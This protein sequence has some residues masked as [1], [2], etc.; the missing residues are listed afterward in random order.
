MGGAGV[1]EGVDVIFGNVGEGG[2]ED[3]MGGGV[4]GGEVAVEEDGVE[5]AYGS[6][7][8]GRRADVGSR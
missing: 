6:S 2:V 1:D 3:F 8:S 4:E 7:V 5:D